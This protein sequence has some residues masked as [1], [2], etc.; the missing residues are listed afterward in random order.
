MQQ[1]RQ[2]ELS[3]TVHAGE[4]KMFYSEA[5]TTEPTSE[6]KLGKVKQK[7]KIKTMNEFK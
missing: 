5:T 3:S 7:K 4:F 6:L 1:A 2:L